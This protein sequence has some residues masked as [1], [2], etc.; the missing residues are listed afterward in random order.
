MSKMRGFLLAALTLLSAA[1][2]AAPQPES[3]TFNGVTGP[4]HFVGGPFVVPNPASDSI[5][6]ADPPD[7]PHRV[8]VCRKRAMNCDRFALTIALPESLRAYALQQGQVLRVDLTVQEQQPL[9]LVK[10]DFHLYVFDAEGTELAHSDFGLPDSLEIRI[11]L[12][13][14]TVPNGDYKVI[15]TGYNGLGARYSTRIGLGMAE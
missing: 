14:E 3:G 9:P 10:P 11:D 1:A 5:Y 2:A 6:L 8:L 13:L 7:Q 12:P 15:V 4:I